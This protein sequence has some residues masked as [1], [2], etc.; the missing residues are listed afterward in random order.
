MRASSSPSE[1]LVSPSDPVSPRLASQ[2]RTPFPLH[3]WARCLGRVQIRVTGSGLGLRNLIHTRRRG[4]MEDV[5][6]CSRLARGV[7]WVAM[8]TRRG[9]RRACNNNAANVDWGTARILDPEGGGA[10]LYCAYECAYEYLPYMR[11][12]GMCG[13]PGHGS[14]SG[15]HQVSLLAGRG[16]DLEHS[17]CFRRSAGDPRLGA[18]SV[19]IEPG[20]LRSRN[21]WEHGVDAR[22]RR[23]GAS[24]WRP[25]YQLRGG[26]G[27]VWRST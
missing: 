24:R 20:G 13:R 5:G 26:C 22:P 19:G 6:R 17:P 12:C 25:E 10:C 2:S 8:S 4:V 14:G 27:A 23:A 21:S 11:E 16:S 3:E 18:G 9:G 15:F 1:P 7:H